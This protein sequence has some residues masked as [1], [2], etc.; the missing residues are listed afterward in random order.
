MVDDYGSAMVGRDK[1]DL[2]KPDY[3]SVNEWG[4][5]SVTLDV[6][7]WGDWQRSLAVLRPRARY[8]HVREMV[9]SLETRPE[10]RIKHRPDQA[11]LGPHVITRVDNPFEEG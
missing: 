8:A 5:R 4:V 3:K 7:K 11:L 2:Y 9:R 10:T 6:L 1:V